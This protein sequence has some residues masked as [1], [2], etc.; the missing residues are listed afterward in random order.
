MNEEDD[1]KITEN[2]IPVEA[3]SNLFI[4]RFS[5]LDCIAVV[6]CITGAIIFSLVA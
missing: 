5:W 1:E 6:L 3:F 2:D 4:T